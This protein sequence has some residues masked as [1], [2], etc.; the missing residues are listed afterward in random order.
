MAL[1]LFEMNTMPGCSGS[2]SHRPS[3]RSW[4]LSLDTKTA[5]KRQT[6]VTS[7][8][9]WI[10]K[11]NIGHT[12]A[13]I[14]QHETASSK[15]V[16][17]GGSGFPQSRPQD[18]WHSNPWA[19]RLHAYLEG[20]FNTSVFSSLVTL[21]IFILG[22]A[23]VFL[24]AW[25]FPPLQ[26]GAP[27]WAVRASHCGGF[28]CCRALSAGPSSTLRRGLSRSMARGSS[29]TQDRP[30]LLHWR[31]GFLCT[32]P[33]GEAQHGLWSKVLMLAVC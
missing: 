5:S 14:S 24:A 17:E 27:L 21:C 19:M 18:F 26:R 20:V 23:W 15:E 8:S 6:H 31:A 16:G 30:C 22:C 28:S 2:G 12:S 3:V 10:V 9:T 13:E 29:Q 25:A 11:Y 7:P 33:P 4:Y 32:V 1:W